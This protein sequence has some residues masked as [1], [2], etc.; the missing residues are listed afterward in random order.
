MAELRE[1]IEELGGTAVAT[2]LNSGN[3]VFQIHM[4]PKTVDGEISRA[5][6]ERFG[7]HVDVVCRTKKQLE[8][9]LAHDPFGVIATDDSKSVIAFMST[10]P[11]AAAIKP[12]LAAEYP[13]GELCALKGREFY[14]WTPN[15]VA[16][17]KS[18]DAFGRSKAA[19]YATVR[20]VRTV[21]KL[22]EIL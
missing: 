8:T 10:P 3:V 22:L 7:F 9:V 14:V 6:S 17:S 15:G 13:D 2:L 5:I 11:R 16:K 18:L 20:N 19:D 1:L 4:S 12:V 21:K